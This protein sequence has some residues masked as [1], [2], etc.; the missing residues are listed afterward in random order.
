MGRETVL[1]CRLFCSQ[2][3]DKQSKAEYEKGEGRRLCAKTNWQ[4]T[5][6]LYCVMWSHNVRGSYIVI[7]DVGRKYGPT[8]LGLWRDV[9]GT[10][11]ENAR[12]FHIAVAVL[13]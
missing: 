7:T 8:I 6:Y 9:G 2:V 1:Q 3:L 13:T 4:K 12:C 11:N 10:M 5:G